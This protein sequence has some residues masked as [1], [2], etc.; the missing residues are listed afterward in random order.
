VKRVQGHK[1]KSQQLR[2]VLLDFTEI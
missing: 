2:R 1:V